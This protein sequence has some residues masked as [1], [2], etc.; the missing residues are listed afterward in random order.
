MKTHFK[1]EDIKAFHS[2]AFDLNNE[3][4]TNLF[5]KQLEKFAENQ[6]EDDIQLAVNY[7]KDFADESYNVSTKINENI[8][9]W[10]ISKSWNLGIFEQIEKC[11]E[12]INEKKSSFEE[13]DEFADENNL[14]SFTDFCIE[15]AYETV[16][17]L[18][19]VID[20]DLKQNGLET[21]YHFDL[22][23]DLNKLHESDYVRI[24]AYLNGFKKINLPDGTEIDEVYDDEEIEE[25]YKHYIIEQF[26]DDLNN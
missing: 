21:K 2:Y 16:E 12:L 26:V 6:S 19:E 4:L 7:V 9:K 22:I 14:S 11:Y 24:N 23:S 10:V 13:L 17:D 18:L 8:F 3:E 15:E 20:E 25:L 1:Y 5:N